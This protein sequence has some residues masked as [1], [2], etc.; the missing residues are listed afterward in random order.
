[1][2][3]LHRVL[4]DHDLALLRL[5]AELW[6]VTLAAGSQREAADELAARM[7]AP[8]LAEEV[9]GAL[10]RDA[11]AGFEQLAREGRQLL[12]SFTRRYGELR[13]MGAARRDRERPWANT[14]SAS[15]VLWYRGLIGRAFFD[16]GRGPEEFVFIPDDLR[17]LAYVAN[18]AQAPARPDPPGRPAP[19]LPEGQ[20]RA[21]GPGINAGG[22]AAGSANA[23]SPTAGGLN[24]SGINASGDD[25]V[26]L[27]AYLQVVPLRLEAAPGAAAGAPATLAPA[28]HRAGLARF[29][30]Q[31][32]ALDFTLHLLRRLSLAEDGDAGEPVKLAPERV[33]PFL[34]ASAPERARQLAEA[35]RDSRE[36]NDLLA[37]PG[38]I[39]EGKS[40][41]N[42]P[43]AARQAILALLAQVPAGQWWSLESFV[44]AVKDR[45]PDFQRPAGDYDS[46]YIRDASSGA[47]L[48]GFENW[49]RV[50]GALVRWLLEQPLA[51]LGLVEISAGAPAGERPSAGA[52]AF[53]LTS[54]GAALLGLAGWPEAPEP[55]SLE[56]TAGAGGLVRAVA[57]EAAALASGYDRFQLARIG[58]WLP[59]EPAEAGGLV[60]PY[61][62]SPASL[63][64]GARK[65]ISPGRILT[66]LERAAAGQ[67]GLPALAAALRRWE[68]KGAEASLGE[69]VVL[70]LASPELLASLRQAPGL[71]ALLGETLGPAAVAVRRADL[72]QVQAALWELGIL[73][74]EAG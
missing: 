40:W 63:A 35:W 10:P 52:R 67:P 22:G 38:L 14:P 33:Q 20:P 46:W 3:A 19:P 71:S 57:G 32:A 17:S 50:D 49:D 45:Q 59:P 18:A 26:T 7:L 36:W 60:Y 53:R 24:T 73:V 74:D 6:G 1:M 9:I 65:G 70:R 5:M 55:A 58:D 23:G 54:Y 47:F 62:L 2:P 43:H 11:R 34:Q 66:F 4:A 21:A 12:A 56:V 8:E 15:E 42:D 28:T 31:P 44:A 64:R 29:L 16:A 69:L 13:A 48:R 61:R 72:E 68:Q 30:R 25:A 41:R 27:L 39:F 37:V 51:G